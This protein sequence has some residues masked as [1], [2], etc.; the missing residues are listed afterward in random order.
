MRR[1]ISKLS[2]AFVLAAMLGLQGCS[3]VGIAQVEAISL[4]ASDKTFVDHLISYG[5]GKDCSI[6]RTE[7]GRE[8]CVEDE[9]KITQNIF[10]YRNLG[11]V[12][13][14]NQPDPYRD[15]SARVGQND[16]NSP[17]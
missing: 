16:Q 4:M 6:V 3:P 2:A 9:K 13:C 15:G 8:Y 17:N 14:Y 12:T 1:A 7:Q 10:C 5:S 11:G